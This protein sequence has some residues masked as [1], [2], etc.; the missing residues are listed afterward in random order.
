VK[1]VS[2]KNKTTKLDTKLEVKPS[3]MWFNHTSLENAEQRLE[4]FLL[5]KLQ[6]HF[7]NSN[8]VLWGTTLDMK[9]HSLSFAEKDPYGHRR[10]WLDMLAP[11]VRAQLVTSLFDL[12]RKEKGFTER[13]ANNVIDKV[14]LEFTETFK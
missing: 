11:N 1:I 6:E 9:N 8:T 7:T 13:Q 10:G 2:K 5:D 14:V 3:Y 12:Y 4:Q